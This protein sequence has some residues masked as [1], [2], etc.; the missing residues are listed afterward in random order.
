MREESAIGKAGVYRRNCDSQTHNNDFNSNNDQK[1]K[2]THLKFVPLATVALDKVDE[3][4][5]NYP[6]LRLGMQGTGGVI[7]YNAV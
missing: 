4:K 1:N 7:V 5:T 3:Q 6:P 2:E